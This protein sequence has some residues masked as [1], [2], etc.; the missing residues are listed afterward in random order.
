MENINEHDMTKKMLGIVRNINEQTFQDDTLIVS[1]GFIVVF[2]H[3]GGVP[4]NIKSFSSNFIYLD[5][6]FTNSSQ[7]YI[8]S[9]V[10]P[11]CFISS[12]MYVLKYKLLTSNIL[13]LVSMGQ[14]VS[15]HFKHSGEI[16]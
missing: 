6:K 3:P 14:N 7:L 4:V 16:Y 2:S 1:P 13:T 12:F 15:I 8:I 9:L 5:M 10:D 11:S